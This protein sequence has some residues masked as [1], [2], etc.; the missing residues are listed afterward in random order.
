MTP[1]DPQQLDAYQQPRRIQ[2][3]CQHGLGCKCQPPYWLRE[4]SPAE[5]ARWAPAQGPEAAE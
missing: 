2:E 1:I 5:R 3:G 4:P